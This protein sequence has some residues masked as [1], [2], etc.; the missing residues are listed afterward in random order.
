MATA[1]RE[2]HQL[3]VVLY[4]NGLVKKDLMVEF[5]DKS[6]TEEAIDEVMQLYPDGI[7]DQ[8]IIG[9]MK[10]RDIKKLIFERTLENYQVELDVAGVRYDIHFDGGMPVA[11]NY[12]RDEGL[13]LED[14]TVYRVG[15]S[16]YF[17]FSGATFPSYKFRN[18]FSYKVK[19]TQAIISAKKS[20]RFFLKNFNSR[21][22]Y[23]DIRA[24]VSHTPYKN[25]GYKTI[26]QIQGVGHLSPLKGKIAT[27]KGIVTSYAT[28]DFYPHGTDIIIQSKQTDGNP[29]TSDAIHVYLRDE[30]K[31]FELGDEVE[32]TGLVWEHYTVTRMT[33]T[34]IRDIRAIKILSK[35]NKL[36]Q[37]TEL[38][39]NG[40]FIPN[41]NI[42]TYNGDL[43]ERPQVNLN[44][45][46]GFWESLE[47]MR[48]RIQNPR[49]VGFRGGN[50]FPFDDE[51]KD[52]L[53]LYLLP[54]GRQSIKTHSEVKG[55]IPNELTGNQN[56][57]VVRLIT[58]NMTK[59]LNPSAI[60]NTGDMIEGEVEGIL[61]YKRNLFG[62]GE[63]AM[64][65]PEEQ[66]SIIAASS[67]TGIRGLIKTKDKPVVPFKSDKDS[68]TIATYN[69]RN[70]SA[71][72]V[73][74]LEETGFMMTNNLK[75]PD[76]IGLVEIQDNNWIS[77]DGNSNAEQ[78][79]DG[80][81]QNL[82]CPG[83][84][85]TYLN[86]DPLMNKE[87][88]QPGGNIRVGYIYD[89]NKVEF[90]QIK[91]SGPLDEAMILPNGSLNYNP[92]RIAPQHE[93]FRGSRKS[94]IAEFI[95]KG[96]KIFIVVNHLNSK[97]GDSSPWGAVQPPV[98]KSEAER[99]QKSIVI[100][101]FLHL[102]QRKNPNAGIIVLGDFNAYTYE[103]SMQLLAH[104]LLNNLMTYNNIVPAN[105]R[106]TTHHDG[107]SQP[108]DYIFVN[109]NLLKKSPQMKVL[110]INSNY[111]GK[112]SDHDPLV[113]KFQF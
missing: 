106:Y 93:A 10:G 86:I 67:K 103:Q 96:Q 65:L 58:G 71:L 112:M 25:V 110:H 79:F 59:G 57:Q 54:D 36:P 64:I 17:R 20:L 66:D 73:D 75:C 92:G 15:L 8:F 62:G 56:P 28:A 52:Y 111:M 47:H 82:N 11:Q 12:Q 14:N 38:G 78:T 42:S 74:R 43:N 72:Q 3:D 49:V 51:S 19:T 84:S 108:L 83:K 94:M 87:G 21:I 60:F 33:A 97:L 81:V 105:E 2:T 40:R 88:G 63:Y 99:N 50:E 29:R 37:V 30:T 16:E 89:E 23:N 85:Y 44:D 32:V 26:A 34:Q 53:T 6:I 80:L 39:R 31:H 61:T 45:G 24:K 4:P 109:N 18:N 76:I 101:R 77:L 41:H 46:I 98:F 70:L 91:K 90:N 107:N 68:L 102:L 13:A 5:N 7:K 100:N 1:M 9:H 95:F 69:V 55:V 48:I 104:R 22:F 35:N 113:A 27:T